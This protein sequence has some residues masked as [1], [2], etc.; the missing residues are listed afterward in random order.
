MKFF[1]QIS[2]AVAK[3]RPAR[4]Y[5]Q[6]ILLT[7]GP[8]AVHRR[9][10]AAIAKGL[11][12]HHRSR[13]F[14]QLLEEAIT[15]YN[16]LFQVPNT[17]QTLIYGGSGTAMNEAMLC[18][19]AAA[20]QGH[21]LI[22]YNGDFGKRLIAMCQKL[23]LPFMCCPLTGDADE[24]T[25]QI[26]DI[27]RQNDIRAVAYVHHETSNGRINNLSWLK[28]L[29]LK[30]RLLIGVDA[31]S[32]IAGEVFDFDRLAPDLVVT[33]S[34]KAIGAFAGLGILSIKR[35]VLAKLQDQPVTTHYL[36]P[37]KMADAYNQ[38]RMTPFTPPTLLFYPFLA[39][40][41]VL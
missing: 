25:Q 32:S 37:G 17:F 21:I 28:D 34:G 8:V 19:L 40:L 23:R 33:S 10:S 29:K 35:S 2:T 4:S 30:C 13:E 1:T 14:S 15:K 24:D 39:A 7:P 9:V 20:G 41:N 18:S 31:I 16:H 22:L 27:L 12:L 3:K 6:K 11:H 26:E 38:N 5:E 36:C